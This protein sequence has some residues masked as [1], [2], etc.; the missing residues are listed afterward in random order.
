MGLP[1]ASPHHRSWPLLVAGVILFLLAF[2]FD[3]RFT[4]WLTSDAVYP[5]VYPT[6][7]TITQVAGVLILI[8]VLADRFDGRMWLGCLAPILLTG[9][10]THA[11]KI[12]VGRTR[13]RVDLGAYHLEP[14]TIAPATA[15]FPSGHTSY[16]FAI[17]TLLCVY[18]PR[19]RPLFIL[20]G[21]CAGLERIIL[22]EHYLSDVI[23]GAALGAGSVWL[24]MRLLGPRFYYRDAPPTLSRS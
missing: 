4:A 13:P 6:L 7:L 10:L 14:F 16:A 8:A 17:V 9:L 18:Y 15:S 3:A 5:C 22:R 1:N 12:M 21:V 19:W 24:T 20:L 23:A 2:A 11:I